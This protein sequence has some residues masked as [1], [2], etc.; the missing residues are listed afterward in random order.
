MGGCGGK[1]EEGG[2]GGKRITKI[3]KF[4][5][6][7][8]SHVDKDIYG[9]KLLLTMLLLFWRPIMYYASA[10]IRLCRKA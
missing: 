10:N 7:K 4:S 9:I 1:R 6:L 5:K 2:K 3:C 8:K